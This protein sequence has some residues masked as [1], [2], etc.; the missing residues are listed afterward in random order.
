MEENKNDTEV[1]VE[2]NEIK[3]PDTVT[4][5]KPDEVVD[6]NKEINVEIIAKRE[7]TFDSPEVRETSNFITYNIY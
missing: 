7:Y 5:V 3:E 6:T 1:P 4:E 2:I